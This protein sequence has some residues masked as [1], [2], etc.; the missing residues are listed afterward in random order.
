MNSYI[1]MGFG[2]LQS[3]LNEEKQYSKIQKLDP[4]DDFRNYWASISAQEKETILTIEEKNIINEFWNSLADFSTRAR[5]TDPEQ[6]KATYIYPRPNKPTLILSIVH[7]NHLGGI[8]NNFLYQNYLNSAVIL[9]LEDNEGLVQ[10]NGNAE[11]L[12]KYAV[13]EEGVLQTYIHDIEILEKNKMLFKIKYS[14]LDSIIETFKEIKG[15]SNV[16][17]TVIRKDQYKNYFFGS[18]TNAM[19]RNYNLTFYN[20]K[21]PTICQLKLTSYLN[22]LMT[23]LENNT[24]RAFQ[25]AAPQ[26]EQFMQRTPSPLIQQYYYHDHSFGYYQPQM[27][28]QFYEG[29][30]I[31]KLTFIIKHETVEEDEY[32]GL[33]QTKTIRRHSDE[34]KG[35]NSEASNA[36][37][38]RL[39]YN[40]GSYQSKN[41]FVSEQNGV[42]Q[43]IAQ[44]VKQQDLDALAFLLGSQSPFVIMNQQKQQSFVTPTK[45]VLNTQSPPL[46]QDVINLG[47]IGPQLSNGNSLHALSTDNSTFSFAGI[48][49]GSHNGNV[50]NESAKQTPEKEAI[51]DNT[52]EKMSDKALDS[53]AKN[54]DKASPEDGFRCK[55]VGKTQKKKLKYKPHDKQGNHA[56]VWVNVYQ[57]NGNGTSTTAKSQNLF[58]FGSDNTEL[59]PPLDE[60]NKSSPQGKI[61]I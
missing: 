4:T 43:S 11:K 60:A 39:R 38:G 49:G 58:L 13:I 14:K 22:S 33:A 25:D 35:G 7:L 8:F 20:R 12:A 23:L 46:L 59:F 45:P 36:Q 61:S 28:S 9:M 6:L 34:T 19:M 3:T 47:N 37:M 57:S 41:F 51:H 52:T 31:G 21:D 15:F 30:H 50:K 56:N 29:I 5:D 16:Q 44:P 40:S 55:H 48:L 42:R 27:N 10:E 26:Y 18:Y 24:R 32:T 2:N 53:L 1:N 54:T 17:E